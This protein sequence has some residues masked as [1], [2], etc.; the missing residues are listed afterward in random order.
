MMELCSKQIRLS[1]TGA[2][3]KIEYVY[4]KLFAFKFHAPFFMQRPSSISV[5]P[6][7]FFSSAKLCVS[8]GGGT[9]LQ[10]IALILLPFEEYVNVFVKRGCFCHKDTGIGRSEAA[11]LWSEEAD[12]P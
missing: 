2:I 6:A 12:E 3:N 1:N 11:Q 7:I 9:R 4:E 5:R 10:S 8:L